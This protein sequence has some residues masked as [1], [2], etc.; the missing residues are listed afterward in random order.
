M[1][2]QVICWSGALTIESFDVKVLTRPTNHNTSTYSNEPITSRSKS[3]KQRQSAGRSSE[4]VIVGFGLTSDWLRK[5][6]EIFQLITARFPSVLTGDCTYT[7][8]SECFSLGLFCLWKMKIHFIAIKVCIVRSTDA[9][10]ETEGPMRSNNSLEYQKRH[11]LQAT[12]YFVT[13]E[14][15]PLV[16]PLCHG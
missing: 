10:V 1:A 4:Q 9:L 6:R 11:K 5:W 2:S 13:L 7:H 14:S 12:G 16:L 15:K 8:Q 3:M